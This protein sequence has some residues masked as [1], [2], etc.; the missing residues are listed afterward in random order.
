MVAESVHCRGCG[1]DLRGLSVRGNCP[2]CGLSIW[3]SVL[4]TVDPAASRL[5]SLRNPMAVGNSLVL[6]T[7]CM[8]LGALLLIM[9]RVVELLGTWWPQTQSWS[10]WIPQFDWRYASCLS[11]AGLWAV[12]NLAP[13]R[14]VEP[15][16]AVRTDLYRIALGLVGWLGFSS[17][18]V[19]VVDDYGTE[20]AAQQHLAFHMAAMVF[21]AIGLI[22]L[23]GVF[24]VIGQ[25]SREYRRSRGGRQ[26]L[27]LIILALIAGFL[28]ALLEYLTRFASF[29]GE[30]RGGTRMLSTL[31]LW[32]AHFMVVVGLGYL[33]VN[34][35][36]IRQALRKPPPP[37]SRVLVLEPPMVADREV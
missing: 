25:R 22:G 29:P 20:L 8:L 23:R 19:A 34:A 31:V 32:A 15:T 2:E 1:Y 35:W 14:N 27:E 4:H 9:P 33:V 37:L 18:W 36:W 10:R 16:G 28:A 5:P 26:S 6:L 21:A 17:A 12:W 13:P 3:S 7:T 30:W 24:R 11:A